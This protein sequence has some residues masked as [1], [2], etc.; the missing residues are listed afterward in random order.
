[1]EIREGDPERDSRGSKRV[2]GAFQRR[3]GKRIRLGQRGEGLPSP[4]ALP[5]SAPSPLSPG[6]LGSHL[7]PSA[8]TSCANTPC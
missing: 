7:P 5:L 1:M 2:G 6:S 8:T 4:G 3:E